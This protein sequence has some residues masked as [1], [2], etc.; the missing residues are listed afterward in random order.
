VANGVDLEILD[1]SKLPC[2]EPLARTYERFLWSPNSAISEPKQVINAMK[3]E[4][5]A[6]GGTL[7]LNFT[8]KLQR[9]ASNFFIDGHPAQ[10]LVNAVGAQSDRLAKEVGL[11]RNYAMVPFMGVTAP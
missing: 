4:F 2:I 11:A 3:T 9:S 8:V 5:E 10:I 1:E 7:K 6:R